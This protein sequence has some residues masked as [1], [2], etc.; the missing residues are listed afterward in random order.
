M[1]L[2]SYGSTAV[3]TKQSLNSNGEH[4]INISSLSD[5]GQAEY[6]R[7]H[8]SAEGPVYLS[9]VSSRC[10]AG[11]RSPGRGTILLCGAPGRAR[12]SNQNCRLILLTKLLIA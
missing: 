3:L 4:H 11:L 6:Y 10:S 9:P 12:H 2:L 8:F 1:S 7:S 5:R